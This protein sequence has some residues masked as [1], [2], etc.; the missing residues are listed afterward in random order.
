MDQHELNILLG[1]DSGAYI[2]ENMTKYEDL[3]QKWVNSSMEEWKAGGQ[4][5]D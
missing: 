2:N 5:K 3:K 1:L 4:G